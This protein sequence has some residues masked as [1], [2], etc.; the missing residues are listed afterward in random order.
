MSYRRFL[1]AL[2][3]TGILAPLNSCTTS[4]GLSYIIISPTA[5]TVTIVLNS[6]GGAAPRS[7]QLP[8]QYQAIGYYTHPNHP[9]E[10]KDLTS[11]V[12]WKTDSPDLVAISTSGL[13]VPAGPVVGN[14]GVFATMPGFNGII[15]SNESNYTVE[16][17]T[18]FETSDVVSLDIEPAGLSVPGGQPIGFA[19][20]GT[21]GTGDTIDLTK[22]SVWSSSNTAVATIGARTGA[23]Q[24]V[25]AGESAIVVTYTNPDGW[26]VTAFTILTVT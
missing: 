11:E 19:V 16:L 5:P 12:S 23:G 8:T 20:I 10:T 6:T 1:G 24:A 2:L 26:K 13:A 22:L 4:P 25:T 7:A 14:G 18:N 15:V 21:T 3:L 9:A 17:P